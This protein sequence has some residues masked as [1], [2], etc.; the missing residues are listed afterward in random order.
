[1]PMNDA[2]YLQRLRRLVAEVVPWQFRAKEVG[3]E[4]RLQQD[5]GIDSL[6]KVMLAYRLE[7]EFGLDLSGWSGD[8]GA[9]QKVS[10]VIALLRELEGS[11]EPRP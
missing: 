10:D 3:P 4:S 1:M 8:V 2:E 6:G 11:R 9:I 7:G 5:L